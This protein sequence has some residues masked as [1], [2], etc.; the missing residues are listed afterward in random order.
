MPQ[1]SLSDLPDLTSLPPL[2]EFRPPTSLKP[3][4]AILNPSFINLVNVTGT[5]IICDIMRDTYELAHFLDNAST[6]DPSLLDRAYFPD[7]I[8]IVEHQLLSLIAQ[9]EPQ[10]SRD[11]ILLPLMH[12]LLLYIYTNIRLTPVDGRIRLTLISRLQKYVQSSDLRA[13]NFSFP[14]ELRWI[15][16]LGGGAASNGTP[17]RAWFVQ[18]MVN[19]GCRREWVKWEHIIMG[20]K[21]FDKSFLARCEEYWAQV[22]IVRGEEGHKDGRHSAACMGEENFFPRESVKD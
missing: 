11:S 15:L 4:F 18:T 13:L 22:G 7:R 12:A 20:L 19:C 21:G 1:F 2:D 3:F 9:A 14:H 17:E 16:F 6:E 5:Q 8:Y 10:L